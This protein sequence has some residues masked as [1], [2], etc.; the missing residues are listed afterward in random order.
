MKLAELQLSV[1]NSTTKEMII[2]KVN[3]VMCKSKCYK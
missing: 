1:S 3:N 2:R